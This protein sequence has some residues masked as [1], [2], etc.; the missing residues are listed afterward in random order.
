MDEAGDGARLIAVPERRSFW[1]FWLPL[2]LTLHLG[3]TAAFIGL[4]GE[5]FFFF[6]LLMSLAFGND[7]TRRFLMAGLPIWL[8]GACYDSMR[9]IPSGWM[10]DV[11]VSDLYLAEKALFGI[12]V[13]GKRLI[14]PE[15]FGTHT[16]VILDLVCGILYLTYLLVFILFLLYLFFRDDRKAQLLGWSF[17]IL[18]VA[19]LVTFQL[20]PAA[21]PWYVALFGLGP[22]DLSVPSNPAG[23]LRFD[24]V[25]GLPIA[26]AIYTKSPEVFGAVPSLHVANPIL[27]FLYARSLSRV[28]AWGSCFYA[29][30]VAFSALYFNHHYVLDIVAAGVYAGATYMMVPWGYERLR[31]RA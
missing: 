25:V 22:A 21:P 18:N 11:H 29:V 14:L 8:F 9:L 13:D 6:F 26:E 20:F 30:A 31:G 16:A 23:M 10:P 15:F 5:H 24:A 28:W 7:R 3:Y 27:V 4:R 2:V 19:G 1:Y 12:V 17:C